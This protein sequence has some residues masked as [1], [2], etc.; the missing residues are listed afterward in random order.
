MSIEFSR[1][2]Y[3]SGLPFPTPGALPNPGIKPTSPVSP[4]LAGRFLNTEP[5]GKPIKLCGVME[6]KSIWRDGE[7][8]EGWDVWRTGHGGDLVAGGEAVLD[9]KEILSG[10]W[11]GA[12]NRPQ[13]CH[14]IPLY[15]RVRPA[16]Y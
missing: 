4:A 9:A 3:W 14:Q 8:Q 6:C 13:L 15:W 5:P 10:S 12:V 7:P 1:Q 16:P 2:E 11:Y